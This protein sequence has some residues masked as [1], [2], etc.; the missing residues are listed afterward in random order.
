MLVLKLPGLP[1]PIAVDSIVCLEADINYVWM[2]YLQNE[3]HQKYLSAKTLKWVEAQL[4]G[5]IRIHQSILINPTHI[6]Q[7]ISKKSGKMVI[8]MSNGMLLPVARRR[9]ENVRQQ[10]EK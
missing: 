3:Q 8:Q 7:T 10:L 4:A 5:F 6:T 9:V 1:K 2:Y